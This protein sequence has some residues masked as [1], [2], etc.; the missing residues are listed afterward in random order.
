M[1][2]QL[3]TFITYFVPFSINRNVRNPLLQWIIPN[4]KFDT[5]FQTGTQVRV[6]RLRTSGSNALK[7]A[8]CLS[9]IGL[10]S[11]L[12]YSDVVYCLCYG[13]TYTVDLHICVHLILCWEDLRTHVILGVYKLYIFASVHVFAYIHFVTQYADWA[14]NILCSCIN[15]CVCACMC[16]S[17]T[18]CM[19]SSSVYCH[20]YSLL[21]ESFMLLA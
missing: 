20:V 13:R 7:G 3:L 12:Y 17:R 19:Y 10:L 15:K 16:R 6:L 5:P 21:H 18:A 8:A 9:R 11:T 4:C 14:Y 1:K 2:Y